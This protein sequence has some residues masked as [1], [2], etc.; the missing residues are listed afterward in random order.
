MDLI[1]CLL[2]SVLFFLNLKS[3][4][5]EL[6]TT[7][8]E[9][10]LSSNESSWDE[11]A[12]TQNS[13]L[14]P[15]GVTAATEE[16]AFGSY[17]TDAWATE[18]PIT[19]SPS[20]GFPRA[21]PTV[22]PSQP[23]ISSLQTP[24]TDVS[25]LCPCNLLENQCDVNCCCD[26]GCA[27]EFALFT[28]CSVQQVI[29]D[30]MLCSQTAAIYSLNMTVN[31]TMQ[32]ISTLTNLINPDFFCIQTNNNAAGLS[33]GTP[34]IPT[35][36]NF[37]TLVKTFSRPSFSSAGTASSTSPSQASGYKY[38]DLIQTNSIKGILT[39]PAPAG[40]S[41]CSNGNPVG[42]LQNQQAQCNVKFNLATDCTN[43]SSVNIA[44][45]S[46]FQ[47]FQTP[48][49]AS[50]LVNITLRSVT[51][52]SLDGMR[53]QSSVTNA[54]SFAPSVLQNGTVCSKVVLQ[55]NYVITYSEAGVIM[56][57]EVSIVLGVVNA[58]P[59]QQSFQVTFVQVKTTSTPVSGNPGYINGL[60]LL[61]G[62]LIA[63]SGIV[64]STNR[65]GQLMVMKSS[66]VQD[67]LALPG[68][69]LPVLFGINMVSGC[70]LR[71]NNIS[72]CSL[73][74]EQILGVLIGS[75]F[76][77]YVA[78]F[79][80][81]QAQN[82]LDWVQI[83]TVTTASSSFSCNIPLSLDL[84]IQW[85]KYGSLVNPQAQIVSL[86][87]KFTTNSTALQGTL[88][89]SSTVSFVDVSAAAQPGYKAPPTID[90]KLPFDFFFPFV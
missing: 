85:T 71:I 83:N 70:S 15:F 61:A 69:R 30:S 3:V 75:N 90:A 16:P 32:R 65:F 87:R 2:G 58:T 41:W 42:F 62:S 53:S 38:G 67:C 64:Q 8:T 77:D 1:L 34:E 25:S 82:V 49:A 79:G 19:V 10:Q 14:P 31:G 74:S 40:N 46:N 6:N 59:V 29:T 27:E 52:Q 12:A 44:S 50:S 72:N 13:S 84:V 21:A 9:S 37:D 60:P 17:S 24:V 66:S 11:D 47:I 39:L 5:S 18:A 4:F 33:F 68:E 43:L 45:Y 20:L 51:L 35:N 36:G 55:V 56:N 57:A 63:G 48:G 23:L 80:N 7:A 73:L 76:P 78:S 54:S 86:T 22:T 81:S 28:G 26:P 88:Q 89:I